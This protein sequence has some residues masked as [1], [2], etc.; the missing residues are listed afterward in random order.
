MNI[1]TSVFRGVAI[2]SLATLGLAA[3]E[4]KAVTPPVVLPVSVVLSPTSVDLDVFQTA[5][6]VAVVLNSTN[7]SVTFASSNTLIATVSPAGL[8]TA[9]APGSA[10]ITVTS[11]ADVTAKAAAIVNVRA[12]VINISVAPAAATI[13]IGGTQQLQAT[14]SGTGISNFGVRWAT[15]SSAVTVSATGLVTGV[16]AGT[17]VVQA[18]S[19]AD[20]AFRANAVITVNPNAPVAVTVTPSQ[21]TVTAGQ[22]LQLVPTVTGTT[23]TAV[24]YGTS[25]A[26]V[27]TVS[28]TGL[29]TTLKAGTAVITVTSSADPSKSA[30]ATITVQAGPTVAVTIS[31]SN[32]STSIGGTV[33]FTAS[34]TGSSNTAVTYTSSN[35][36]IATVNSTTG[37]ATGVAAGS[38]VITATSSADATKTAT[39]VLTV[40]ANPPITLTVSPTS[41]T[42]LGAGASTQILGTVTGSTNQ[43]VTCSSAATGVATTTVTADGRGCNVTGVNAGSTVITITT[44]ATPSA[45]QTVPVTVV[46]ASVAIAGTTAAAPPAT[47]VGSFNVAINVSV[48]AGTADQLILRLTPAA[49]GAPIDILCQTFTSAGAATTVACAVNPSDYDPNTAGAQVLQNGTYN[50]EA[51]L[52]KNGALAANAVFGQ[53][54]IT[55]NP[56]TVF[57]LLGLAQFNNSLANTDNTPAGTTAVT[58]AGVTWYGGSATLTLSPSIFAGN[59]INTMTVQLD[60]GC[61][62]GVTADPAPRTYTVGTSMVWS[63]A[64]SLAGGG[65]ND[66]SNAA[67]CFIVSNARDNNGATVTLLPGSGSGAVTV[68]PAGAINTPGAGQNVWPIDNVPTV[69]GALALP[70]SL[71]SVAPWPVLNWAGRNTNFSAT[72]ADA[73]SGVVG[74]DAGVDNVTV[75]FYAV[76]TGTAVATQAN[77]AAAVISA[78]ARVVVN[79]AD[80]GSSSL[81]NSAWIL[82]SKSVDALGNTIY[83]NIGTFGVDIDAPTDAADA[84]SMPSTG[85][86]NSAAD[87][88]VNVSDVHSGPIQLEFQGTVWSVLEVNPA[89]AATEASCVRDNAGTVTPRT[90]GAPDFGVCPFVL[91]ALTNVGGTTEQGTANHPP[92][93]GNT[94]GF[95]EYVV[96]GIDRA[97]NRGNDIT[98]NTLTDITA[99]VGVIQNAFFDFAAGTV[100]LNGVINENVDL[101]QY[102]TRFQY[103]GLGGGAGSGAGADIP[104]EVPFRTPTQVDTYGLPLTGVVQVGGGT[105]TSL[106]VA[107]IRD[108][109]GTYAA[110]QFGFGMT[111]VAQNYAF[112]GL[113]ITAA[114]G[115]GVF[116]DPDGSGPGAPVLL[117]TAQFDAGFGAGI[118]NATCIDRSGNG[119]ACGPSTTLRT[120]VTVGPTSNNPISQLFFYIVSPGTDNAF[121]TADDYNVLIAQQTAAQA[122][123]LTGITERTFTWQTPVFPNVLPRIGATNAYRMYT[124]GVA[125]NGS[126]IMSDV[127]ALTIQ[128]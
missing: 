127:V 115:P 16:S 26:T 74:A 15:L 68:G 70:P 77:M 81:S 64:T 42:N 24:T 57:G 111:D 49:G 27:A 113:N 73:V 67:N 102:D 6:L 86:I 72:G 5:S 18:I 34:V 69:L 11:A 97:G 25:D 65:I 121:G 75:T 84:T 53:Q 128:D 87:L 123:P 88:V 51:R 85:T 50:V 83:G 12:R 52:M 119:G 13:A 32:A 95:Y 41:I 78:G 44:V 92:I 2:L 38:T 22:T 48:P 56:N 55:G 7:Q 104:D 63:E 89:N 10:T 106:S 99:P 94:E 108:A 43:S 61:D 30:L 3:C 71:T 1:R 28:T 93:A 21:A 59:A 17:A 40:N 105:G 14:V 117:P 101:L 36:A 90:A 80:L 46:G 58:P 91:V 125:A 54:I 39:A 116:Y 107:D 96:R 45:T 82:V 29:V 62:A 33:Q 23:N 35:A 122:A 120:V 103:A 79:A 100:T 109:T 126:A 112:S 118:A 37:V 20:S 66:L 31:P 4:S 76:P 60:V 114:A 110:N 19:L 9:V 47:T 98:A 124:I 8:I